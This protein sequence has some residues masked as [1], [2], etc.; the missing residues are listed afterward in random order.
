MVGTFAVFGGL[1]LALLVS[2][3][4]PVAAVAVIVVLLAA[5]LLATGVK[6]ALVRLRPWYKEPGAAEVSAAAAKESEAIT[7]RAAQKWSNNPA[8]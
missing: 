5:L 6:P 4:S 2:L 8:G 3:A 1:V 7:I